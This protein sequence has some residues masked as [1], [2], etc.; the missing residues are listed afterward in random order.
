M[1]EKKIRYKPT[2]IT[3]PIEFG[4]EGPI[5]HQVEF[6][7]TKE[8]IEL[9]IA[10]G[11]CHPGRVSHLPHLKRYSYFHDLQQQQENNLDFRVD[12][13]LGKRWLELCEFAPLKHFRGK[14]ELVP[15]EWDAQDMLDLFLMLVEKKAV[16][17]DGRNVILIIY[18]THRTLFVPPPI[19][20]A[21]RQQLWNR[22]PPFESVYYVSPH[23]S[24]DMSVWEV[25]P[26][27]PN[28]QGWA[29]SDGQL[30]VGP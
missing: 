26:G 10:K 9:F 3:G 6:P 12:T 5:R 30:V 28:E 1:S 11:F 27:D 14:Y 8:E 25:W 4:A 21:A 7:K 18:K 2:G 15:E 24:S 13:G 23:S 19:I 17:S 20:R 16:K 22:P 29:I